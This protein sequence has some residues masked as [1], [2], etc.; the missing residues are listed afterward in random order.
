MN[1]DNAQRTKIGLEVARCRVANGLAKEQ[2]AI[3]AGVS[4]ITW[5]RVEDGEV[6]RDAN[7]SK[8]LKSLDLDADEILTGVRRP[9]KVAERVTMPDW[10]ELPYDVLLDEFDVVLDAVRRR[11]RRPGLRGDADDL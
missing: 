3:K 4:S 11:R 10:D 6:T 9:A 5:K 8:V 2:A 7:L 1:Y